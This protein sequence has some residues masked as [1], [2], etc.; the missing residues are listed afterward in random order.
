MATSMMRD[1]ILGLRRNG[2][3]EE[4]IAEGLGVDVE[5]VKLAL[6]APGGSTVLRREARIDP[7]DDEDVSREESREMLGII[8]N[9]ARDEES[10]IYAKL[11]AAKYVYGVRNGYHKQH[12]DLNL[13]KG[14]LMLRIAAAYGDAKIRSLKALGGMKNVTPEKA[15][16]AVEAIPA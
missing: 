1:Q 11:S 10:P 3:R 9:I 12:G 16:T 2:M 5:V 7:S 14:D 13:D 8:S 6:T 15:E 4:E